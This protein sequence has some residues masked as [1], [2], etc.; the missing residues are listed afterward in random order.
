MRSLVLA[1]LTA[2]LLVGL[3]PAEASQSVRLG[4][5]TLSDATERDEVNLPPCESSPNVK[6]TALKVEVKKFDAQIDLLRIVYQNGQKEELEL[7]NH[8]DAGTSSRWLDLKGEARCIKRIVIVGDTDTAR[9]AP[10]KQAVVTFH[11]RPAAEASGKGGTMLG[12]VRLSDSLD[13]DELTFPRCKKSPNTPVR[14]L[15]VVVEEHPAT[16]NR[17][18]VSFQNGD[19][20][21]LEMRARFEAGG[22]S[23]WIDMPG[24][25][26]CV[27]KIV[28]VGDT[29]TLRVAPKRQ[30]KVTF[31]GK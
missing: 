21:E 8:L 20:T 29:D 4:T 3:S 11:G 7:R 6:V 17:L 12:H 24:D 28:I 15:R 14:S 27:A 23:R 30:A 13:R 2:L 25:E 5:V 1:L 22:A 19:T 26:R 18:M 16:I 9:R 31:Y 10:K